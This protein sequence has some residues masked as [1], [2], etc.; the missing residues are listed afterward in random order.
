MLL[1]LVVQSFGEVAILGLKQVQLRR[2]A[3]F[4]CACSRIGS[5]SS[6][7]LLVRKHASMGCGLA[8]GVAGAGSAGHM[9]ICSASQHMSG[10]ACNKL[11]GVLGDGCMV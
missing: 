5:R 3:A 4:D 6:D 7:L 8:A 11:A 9:H 2:C 1:L 10:H